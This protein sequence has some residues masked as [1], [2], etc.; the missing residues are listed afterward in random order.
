MEKRDFDVKFFYNHTWIGKPICDWC[1]EGLETNGQG[2]NHELR[3]QLGLEPI[4]TKKGLDKW[5]NNPKNPL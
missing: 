4:E 5:L 3:N 2:T 1:S